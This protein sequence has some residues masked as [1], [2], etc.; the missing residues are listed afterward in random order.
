MKSL[1]STSIVACLLAIAA[2]D[3]GEKSVTGTSAAEPGTSSGSEGG[4]AE[5]SSSGG[6]EGGSESGDYGGN[7]VET[8]T[9][10]AGPGSAGPTGI[11]PAP[12]IA[13][14]EGVYTG[15]MSWHSEGPVL[16][17][18]AV[19]PTP[20]EIEVAYIG[21]EIRDIDAELVSP[22]QHDGPCPCEDSLE[23]D[24]QLRIVSGDGVLDETWTVALKH[25]VTGG[26][27]FTT[28]GTSMFH[29]FEPDDTQGT[30]SR[31]SF[32]LSDG[33]TLDQMVLTGQFRDGALEGGLGVEVSLDGPGGGFG[34]FGSL[35]SFGTVTSL[36]ACPGLGGNSC[37]AAGCTAVPARPVYGVV[38]ACDCGDAES[39]CFPGP[40]V[41]ES[42]PT[43]Y[44][45][46]DVYEEGLDLVYE[47]DTLLADP[48]A[49]WRLCADAPGVD[50]CGC[51]EG[52]GSC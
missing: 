34:G 21:G 31:A 22:C 11:A 10:L 27:G 6:S 48:P 8:P 46:P 24:V 51:F 2:C 3:P 42:I 14:A 43:L 45:R 5:G 29:G 12:V 17:E 35:A 50:Y 47:L 38:P 13:E 25:Y 19:G 4:S 9:V 33:T 52:G 41:G 39:F 37:E 1:R 36:E 7:C 40:L 20:V 26:D 18:G 32:S 23:V 44:T 28:P 30:L 15:N 49:P 16:Y